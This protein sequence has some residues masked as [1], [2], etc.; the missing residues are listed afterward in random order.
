MRQ[1]RK[2]LAEMQLGLGSPYGGSVTWFEVVWS[3]DG[4]IAT[5]LQLLFL[6]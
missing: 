3:Q 5:R 6:L 4:W 2:G 1:R